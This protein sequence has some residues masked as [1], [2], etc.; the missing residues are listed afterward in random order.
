MTNHRG[1]QR[2]CTQCEEPALPRLVGGINKGYY[3][4]CQTHFGYHHKIGPNH[5]NATKLGRRYT[6]DG[7]IQI[8]DPT[9]DK[10]KKTGSNYVAEH[11]YV[12]SQ[13]LGRPLEK[14]EVVH[15]KNG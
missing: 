2:L 9:R 4:T 6:E 12:M 8:L 10:A 11:R 3:K 7:Y 14:N 15:H 13:S 5:C 1:E